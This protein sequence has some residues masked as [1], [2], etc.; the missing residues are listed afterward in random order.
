[1]VELGINHVPVVDAERNVSG[2]LTSTDITSE[3]SGT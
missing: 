2:I 1:M 3:L